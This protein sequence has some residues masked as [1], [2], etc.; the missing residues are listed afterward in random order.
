MSKTLGL[1]EAAS[2]C[3]LHPNTLREQ[4]ASGKAPGFA[5]GYINNTKESE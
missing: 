5:A 1:V 4:A 3:R 2:L